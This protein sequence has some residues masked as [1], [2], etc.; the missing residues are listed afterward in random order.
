MLGGNEKASENLSSLLSL[1]ADSNGK[2]QSTTTSAD[3]E[4]QKVK[5]ESN[6]NTIDSIPKLKVKMRKPAKIT[7][8]TM[9]K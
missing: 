4:V 5:D 8:R 3:T 1:L 9:Q 2:D 7:F 6:T